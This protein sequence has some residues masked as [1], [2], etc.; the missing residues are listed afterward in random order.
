MKR[1]TLVILAVALS[2]TISGCFG[3]GGSTID[4]AGI[5]NAIALRINAFVAAVEDYDVDAMLGFLDAD[6]FSLTIVEGDSEYDKTYDELETELAE[7]EAKQLH[8]REA[9]SEGGHGYVLTMQLGTTTYTNVS[10]TG[11]QATVPFTIKEQSEDPEIPETTTD[12][13]DIVFDMVKLHG[14][15]LCRTMTITFDTDRPRAAYRATTGS[16]R[17]DEASGFGLGRFTL[18]F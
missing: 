6:D 17:G 7:D 3:G 10:E 5:Q 13:G 18:T 14:Q 11:A 8:W 4:E 9:V 2:L 16:E 12:T 1:L 15:W